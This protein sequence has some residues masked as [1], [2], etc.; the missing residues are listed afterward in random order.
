MRWEGERSRGLSH[1]LRFEL[2]NDDDASSDYLL[3]APDLDSLASPIILDGLS[4]FAS[5]CESCTVNSYTQSRV[6][7][8]PEWANRVTLEIWI[9]LVSMSRSFVC[10][11]VCVHFC[12]RMC[13]CVS[14]RT[15]KGVA[16][17][18]EGLAGHTS[19]QKT[20]LHDRGGLL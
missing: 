12:E 4:N 9:E 15:C 19:M 3:H 20:D 10:V 7:P 16:G 8:Y 18:M 6:L 2:T 5:M 11:H 13:L 1:P 14:A 17:G